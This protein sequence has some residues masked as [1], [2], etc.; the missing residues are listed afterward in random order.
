[1]T[2]GANRALIKK[3]LSVRWQSKVYI[4]GVHHGL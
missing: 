2:P 1:V 4:K 3:I